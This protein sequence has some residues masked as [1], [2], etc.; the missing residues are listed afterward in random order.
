MST[1]RKILVLIML[2][3]M[4]LAACGPSE[5]QAPAA[6]EPP[7]AT[8]APGATEAPAEEPAATEAPTQ[9]AS[10]EKV[11]ITLATWAGA[12]ESNEL[13]AVIDKVNAEA[14]DFEIV[15]QAN[16]ADYYTKLQTIVRMLCCCTLSGKE[17]MR[18]AKDVVRFSK[19]VRGIKQ[20]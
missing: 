20:S 18:F 8:E 16:P 2:A 9:A 15:H 4:L 17:V 14:T 19:Y 5:T 13:Q 3:S 7:A 11:T 1:I 6:T 12:E 10:G